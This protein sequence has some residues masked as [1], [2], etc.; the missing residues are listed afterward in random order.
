M[1]K[2]FEPYYSAS[3]KKD[4]STWEY[5][6]DSQEPQEPQMSEQ[7]VLL[8]ELD[9][10]RQEAQEKGY[11]EGLNKAHDEI[12]QQKSELIYLTR[13]MKKP[14]QLIDDELTQDLIHTMI[15]LCQYCIGIELSIHPEQL[16]KIF[17]DIKNELPL[18]R[19]KKQLGMN[20]KDIEWL[21]NSLSEQQLNEISPI[22]CED[23]TLNRGDFYLKDE[24]SELDGRLHSRLIMLFSKHLDQDNLISPLNSQD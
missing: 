5:R 17:E 13:L 18:L 6:H 3:T 7:E 22:L 12:E 24:N 21:R 8:K 14:M 11:Q 1:S 15:W 23:E 4:F 19:G 16:N 20:L 10:L 9:I 2:E